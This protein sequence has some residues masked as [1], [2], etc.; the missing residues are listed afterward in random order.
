MSE[1]ERKNEVRIHIDQQP[2]E[3][4]SPATGVAL[5]VLGRVQ[6]GMELFR[7]VTGDR[8]DTEV[9]NGPE[10]VHLKLDE[11]FH[12][13]H[14][15]AYTIYVN[16]EQKEINSKKATFT[17]IVKLAFPI[18]PVGSNIL[19]TV[20]YE[21]GPHA[22]PQGSLKDGETIKVKNGMIFNVSATDKS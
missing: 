9:P 20:S 3:V 1:H 12:S 13:G 14:P 15:K 18:P 22:N 6:P 2:Y 8:E 4:P 11:H 10:L 19:Y 16:G 5:Y 21:D 7:E 17:E